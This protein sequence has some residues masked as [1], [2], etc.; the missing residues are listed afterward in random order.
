MIERPILFGRPMVHA[1]I[2]G[3]KTKTR[4]V[5]KPQPPSDWNPVIGMYSP[6]KVGRDGEEYPGE[7]VFGA[8]DEVFGARCPYGAPGDRLWVK[9]TWSPWADNWTK[10]VCERNEGERKACVYRADHAEYFGAGEVGGDNRWHPSIH[11]P[12]AMSRID[13]LVK[14]I[15]V[16]RVQ[17]IT[18][19]DAR[20]EGMAVFQRGTTRHEH[21]NR[22]LFA[23][24][25]DELNG[26]RGYG[27]AKNPFV[28][29]IEFER[30][31]P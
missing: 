30:V 20:A 9:E 15:R 6:T 11:M 26:P 2:D 10:A 21:E 1:T 17:D 13:L 18:E 3:L 31:K 24:L 4:R 16:E 23:K 22:D 29:V 14:A 7:E 19:E 12:R 27:W 5:V 28:W 25:W 8:S